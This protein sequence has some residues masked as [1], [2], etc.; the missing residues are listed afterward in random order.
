MMLLWLALSACGSAETP[1]PPPADGTPTAGDAEFG[2]AISALSP[3]P[4]ADVVDLDK[5]IRVVHQVD[6]ALD[7]DMSVADYLGTVAR[8]DYRNVD[9]RVLEARKEILELQFAIYAKQT[10]IADREASWDMTRTLL[11]T[12]S[13][14]EAKGAV[15]PVGPLG[16]TVAVDRE[17]AR[18]LLEEARIEAMAQRS[19]KADVQDLEVKLF[20]AVSR[21]ST[22]Y[23]DQMEAWDRLCG[24]RDRAYLAAANGDWDTVISASDAAI[25]L[26]PS[27][28][29]A[30]LLQARALI[31]RG[32]PEDLD[33]A[34]GLLTDY[35]AEHPSQD[36]PALLLMGV[37]HTRQGQKDKATLAYQESAAH[38][39]KQAEALADM[40]D[41]YETRSWLR[42]SREGGGIVDQYAA[43]M[44]GAGYF[45]PDLQMAR[46]AFDAKD[47]LGGRQK[48][49]DHFA[50]R[51]SEAAA[52]DPDTQ[53][54]LWG[55]I[56]QDIQYAQDVLG[57]HF[58]ELF[59]E[60]AYVDLQVTPT[61]LYPNRE[62]GVT[63][64]NRSDE[65]LHNATLVLVVHFTDMHPAD[66]E[67]FA[68]PK[69]MP[70]VNA[71]SSTD[72][73]TMSLVTTLWGQ[74][75]GVGDVVQHRAI[76]L[77]DEAVLWVDTEE[78]KIA[79]AKEFRDA[80]KSKVPLPE[81][82]TTWHK[83]MVDTYATTARGLKETADVEVTSNY[84]FK[85]DVKVSLPGAL[86]I[87]K[88]QFTL[89]YG[90]KEYKAATNIVN[91]EH[92]ELT[93]AGVD[94]FDAGERPATD[95]VLVMNSVYGDF[96]T[97]WRPDGPMAWSFSATQAQ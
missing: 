29:E 20:D 28:R 44:L 27:E 45:S 11:A 3:P 81:Q 52:S 57:P 79:E 60:D 78:F 22:V 82:K 69:T 51:R 71:R 26:A 50:R 49:L 40:L 16:G 59:P 7:Q 42:K 6:A 18:K 73:G 5:T 34:K 87:F 62:V 85:D 90:G 54:K 67:P 70:S 10:E 1:S 93:F 25:A 58:R 76:L 43:M 23:W 88:P 39:P 95:L 21:Y 66:Y 77:T 61:T 24:H 64:V 4:K 48:V 41:P 2:R 15:G 36:A 63:V 46:G 56:L 92:I 12:A 19:L 91:G 9:P 86:A 72:F 30:H 13:V 74:E 17:Q 32:H 89:K 65:T 35:I 8:E 33:V 97:T 68:A 75:K 53:R 55:F 37:V 80:L 14:V 96:S 38:Y 83:Q 84:G 47:T 94:N 31:E